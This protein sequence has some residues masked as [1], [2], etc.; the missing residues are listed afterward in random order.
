[1]KTLSLAV[2]FS[3]LT[4]FNMFAQ[5][6]NS[7][8]AVK[9]AN[10]DAKDF[11]LDDKIWKEFKHRQIGPESDYFKPNK[12]TTSDTTLLRDSTY[13]QAYRSAA[14]KRTMGRHTTAHYILVYGTTIA[15]L[16]LIG[17]AIAKSSSVNHK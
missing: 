9:A 3:L 2:L 4:V 16:A 15:A 6:R 14:L 1:M 7:P 5:T 13:V 12:T 10:R 11:Q 8:A 17:A